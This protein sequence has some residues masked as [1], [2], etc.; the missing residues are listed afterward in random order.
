MLGVSACLVL[1]ILALSSVSAKRSE[2]A[3][4]QED[5]SRTI[6]ALNTSLLSALKDAE[7]GQRGYLLTGRD[8]YLA[9]YNDALNSIPPLLRDLDTLSLN[10]LVSEKLAELKAT[11]DLRRANRF[12]DAL[13][14]VETD[15]GKALMDEIRWRCDRADRIQT[16]RAAQFNAEA[17]K[18]ALNLRVIATVGSVLLLA[19]LGLSTVTVFRGMKRREEMLDRVYAS[20]K[21][22]VTTLSGIADGVIAA[23][24]DGRITFINPVAQQLTGWRESE[25]IGVPVDRVF[26]IVHETTRFEADN[27]LEKAISQG[28]VVWLGD[29]TNLISK[30]GQELP[31]DDSAAPLKDEEGNI[32]GAVLV[33]RDITAR[34]EAEKRL[35]NANQEL[36]QFVDAAAH[37]LRS[38]LNSV[39]SMAELLERRFHDQLGPEGNEVTGYMTRGLD[40]MRQLLDD[41]LEFARSSH[42]DSTETPA[43]PLQ[44]AL[45]SALDNLK[46]EIERTGAQVTHSA[47]PVAQIQEAHALQLF[48]NLISNAIKYAGGKPPI[49]HIR[50][51]Q[52]GSHSQIS[53]S[54]NGI[55]IRPEFA[56]TI[57]KPF[58]RLHGEE[59][60]GSGIGLATCEKI[61]NGYGGRIWMESTPGSGAI[62]YFTLPVPDKL[63]R[64]A[65]DTST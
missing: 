19:F 45:E 17:A 14:V 33:F 53:V 44:S 3:Q 22:L 46:S 38:P 48:Q 42:F 60:P 31:I 23:D 15:R 28:V 37:D 4:Q 7:T 35:H 64:L 43:I 30:S 62:F 27:P 47:M 56:K 24:A 10:T 39:K 1:A 50:S 9:P 61:V 41:L 52:N 2:R 58:K 55:G 32:I 57:F 36:Q 18:S 5:L 12:Q 20:E 25:A 59:L 29:H 16:D 34:R 8:E 49:I 21:L 54:D 11:I 51:E 13:A 26:K 63:S 65:A 6:A 40:R